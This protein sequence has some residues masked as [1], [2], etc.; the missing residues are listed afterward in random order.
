MSTI[1]IKHTPT[2]NGNREFNV[3]LKTVRRAGRMLEREGLATV[4]TNG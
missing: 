1:E 4:K 2:A 3:D